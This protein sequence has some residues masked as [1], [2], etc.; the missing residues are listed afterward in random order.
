MP[1]LSLWLLCLFMAGC[2]ISEDRP[3]R[4]APQP[5]PPAPI[6]QPARYELEKPAHEGKTV[7]LSDRAPVAKETNVYAVQQSF[8]SAGFDFQLGGTSAAAP[9]AATPPA[10]IEVGQS[11]SPAAEMIDVEARVELEVE[12]IDP[13][14]LRIR[15]V[16]SQAGG[17]VVN[18]VVE[19]K[20]SSSG[21]AL[22]LRVPSAKLP[23][24]LAELAGVGRLL[25]RK[26]ESRDI[27]REYH[28]AA[29]LLRNL[30][31]TLRRYEELLAKAQGTPQ[32]LEIERELSRVRTQLDRVKG[33]MRWLRDRATR[34]TI[35]VT[36]SAPQPD[37]ALVEP[38][39]K[40]FPGLRA[41]SLIDMSEDGSRTFAGGGLSIMFTRTFSLDADWLT[42]T[43]NGDGVDLFIATAGVELYS[44]L[45]GG[46]RR[47]FLNPYLGFRT[48][49]ARL[50]GD[51]ALA[52]GGAL[53]LELWKTE[54]I[55]LDLQLRAYALIEVDDSTHAALQPALAVN[56]AY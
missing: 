24:V 22:S 14:V 11:S 50:L 48:G 16:V 43:R 46:G 2:L 5:P 34:A 18:E 17:Q 47:R 20:T 23:S 45:L 42:R 44:D 52:V 38:T 7:E 35:Y 53:G 1:A 33:D 9:Q 27:G 39:A 25:S 40:L 6:A 56:V 54:A 32:V 29:I 55:V 15:K 37:A 19:A 31:A 8:G 26:I 21:A 28:D 10:P 51:G 41:T 3:I 30:E 12:S 4:A 13:A 36:L 49:Y